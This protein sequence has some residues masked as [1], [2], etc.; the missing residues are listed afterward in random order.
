MAQTE[1][2]STKVCCRLALLVL[3][4]ANNFGKAANNPSIRARVISTNWRETKAES[5]IEILLNRITILYNFQNTNPFQALCTRPLL[6]VP[7]PWLCLVANTTRNKKGIWNSRTKKVSTSW[8]QNWTTYI[9]ADFF[10]KN[11]ETINDRNSVAV[12]S[13]NKYF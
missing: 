6:I 12:L 10:N 2:V 11:L 8:F 13:L 5:Y 3:S 1:S 9:F 7:F 4:D